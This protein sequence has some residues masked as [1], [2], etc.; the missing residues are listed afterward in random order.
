MHQVALRV[1]IEKY[2]VSVLAPFL[3]LFETWCHLN[4]KTV[5]QP[6]G[7]KTSVLIALSAGLSVSGDCIFVMNTILA[8]CE[9]NLQKLLLHLRNHNFSV[10]YFS[11]LALIRGLRSASKVINRWKSLFL[12]SISPSTLTNTL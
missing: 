9:L 10:Q 4:A 7:R 8:G 6:H 5:A 1:A 12:S 11:W 2:F 3:T